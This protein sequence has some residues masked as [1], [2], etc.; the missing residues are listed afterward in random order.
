MRF[1]R[2]VMGLGASRT[3]RDVVGF[4]FSDGT[5]MEIWRAENEFHSFFGAGPIVGFRVGDGEAA[6]ASM[7]ATA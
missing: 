1:F 7:E 5:G 4:V 2:G 6:R 3:E